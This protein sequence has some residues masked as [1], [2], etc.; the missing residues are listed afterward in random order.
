M[1]KRGRSTDKTSGYI[2][3]KIPVRSDEEVIRDAMRRIRN[4]HRPSMPVPKKRGGVES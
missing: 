3:V 2:T 4:P 1:D